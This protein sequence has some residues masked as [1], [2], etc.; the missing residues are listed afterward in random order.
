MSSREVLGGAAALAAVATLLVLGWSPGTTA[1]P[2]VPCYFIFGDSLVDNGNN[3]NMAS[4]A[5]ANYPPYGID[6]DGGPNGRFTNGLTT[7]DVIAQLLG[8]D[9]FIPPYIST[10]GQALLS[11]AN[12][13]SA[14]AGIREE[15]GRQLGGRIPFGG[16][17]QNYQSAVAEMVSL[18][19]D[20]DSAANYLSKCIFSVGMGSNDYLNNYFMPA[21]YST[22]QQYTPEQ[23]ADVLL[24]Q[25]SEQL[26]TLYNYGARKVAV[27]GVGQVGCS[28]NELAQHSPN[29][30]TCV[31]EINSAIRIFNAK[32]I[33]LVDQFNTLD[34]AHFI[35][36]NGYGI[37]EDI[38]NDAGSYGLSVTNRGCCGVGRNNG[39]ITC[40]P[41]QAPCPNRGEYLFFDA[42][43]PTEAANVVIGRRSYRAESPSDAYPMDISSLAQ[44]RAQ[45]SA[46]EMAYVRPFSPLSPFLRPPLRHYAVPQFLVHV[47]RSTILRTP[48]SPPKAA[49]FP[50]LAP[51]QDSL[52]HLIRA[53]PPTWQSAAASNLLIF[54]VGSP[55][56]FSGL[57]IPGIGSAFL[58]GVLSWRAFGPSGFLIVAAYFVI[59]TAVTKLKIAQK[60]ALGIAEKRSGRR[61]PGS[62]VGSSA[63]ACVCAVL[64]IFNI[65]GPVF[66]ALW[67]LGFV[68]SFSTKLSDTVSSEIG[69]AYG[70]TTYSFPN[71]ISFLD[72]C[73]NNRYLATTFKVVPRGTE[74]AVSIEGTVAGVVS[75]ILLAGIACSLGQVD[76]PKASICILASLIA[77]FCESL[78][79]ATL[80]D[81][82]SF[83][84]LSNDIVNVIN[85]SIGSILAMLIQLLILRN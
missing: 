65:G 83:Q 1:D 10:R 37:F 60:E 34:G 47:P 74:G 49:P 66:A 67:Q 62:V 63:A 23:F 8:F 17:L 13:A 15:T 35:Y 18:L 30:V 31:E 70:K 59:G 32:V 43:H 26:R 80:Q 84:W 38:L 82:D 61:G 46:S 39:Q 85:I 20:E 33:G 45:F 69:K 53:S 36:V 42:F 25:Y 40:L 41:Y 27:I 50:E 21:F 4:L 68:A 57:T 54:A 55:I 9:D 76:L 7:V 16:Q 78:I 3:N 51:L 28:P 64:S 71:S 44:L 6:F 29:G 22:G 12:F 52:L 11:G 14:A 24:Q 75:S 5:V 81:K 77:N 19:G 2:Q 58:L 56:L 73:T 79:G 48:H 72:F